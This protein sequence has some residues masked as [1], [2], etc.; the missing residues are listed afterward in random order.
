MH[1]LTLRC[2]LSVGLFLSFSTAAFS[3][4]SPPCDLGPSQTDIN[5]GGYADQFISPDAT[6]IRSTIDCSEH[7]VA[8][9]ATLKRASL[10]KGVVVESG[11]TIINSEIS[12]GVTVS[13]NALVKGSLV[14]EPGTIIGAGAVVQGNS[15]IFAESW[16]LPNASIINSVLTT[17]TIGEGTRV[18]RDSLVMEFNVGPAGKIVGAKLFG[19]ERIGAGSSIGSGARIYKDVVITGPIDIGDNVT[20][21]TRST[22]DLDKNIGDNFYLGR[23]SIIEVGGE[24]LTNTRIGHNV[25]VGR[26][27][28]IGFG[29]RIRAFTVLAGAFE[30]KEFV[31]IGSNVFI[32]SDVFVDARTKIRSRVNIGF[33][34]NIG[35]DV[36]IQTD[37][38]VGNRVTIED[39]VL[40]RSGSSVP[41]NAYLFEN[42]VFPNDYPSMDE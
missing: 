36:I 22:I 14:G 16:V 26:F 18:L 29:N 15:K 4:S 23:D 27:S 20:I 24:I 37:A 9:G 19:E 13:E 25:K 38:S 7:S 11:A 39:G 21:N 34:V 28:D 35:K 42:T 8:P 5:G 41:D 6:V 32:N 3:Q 1:S 10:S 17:A 31:T 2:C 12:D 30:S 33:L 40:V